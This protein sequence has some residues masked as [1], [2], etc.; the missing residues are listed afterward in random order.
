MAAENLG[1][2]EGGK[3]HAIKMHESRARLMVNGLEKEIG[4]MGSR[5]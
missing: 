3:G 2:M 4:F 5:G 1:S